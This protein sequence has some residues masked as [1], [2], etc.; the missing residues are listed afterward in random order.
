VRQRI[1]WMARM[2]LLIFILA[3]AAFLSAITAMRFAIRGREVTMPNL[4]GTDSA[5]AQAL[6]GSRGLQLRVVDRIY[7]DLPANAVA[8]QSPAP[9]QPLKISQDA[10]VVL[11]L[12]PQNITV[13]SL[14][15]RSLRAARIQLLQSGLQLAEVTTVPAPEVP[16]DTVLQQS[17]AGGVRAASPRVNLLVSRQESRPAYVMPSLL[18]VNLFDAQRRFDSAG[19]KITKIMQ[20]SAPEWP[21][22]TIIDQTPGAGSKVDAQSSVQ[23]LVAE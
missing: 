17:P 15:A 6:L 3:A 23:V 10:Q 13:P 19:L 2:G 16:D 4:I 12:G 14:T 9:G 8:R 7:G 18:G 5:E 11:S 20:A 22:G 21:R 1:E